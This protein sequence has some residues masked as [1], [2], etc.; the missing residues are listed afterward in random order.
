MAPLSFNSLVAYKSQLAANKYRKVHSDS[1]FGECHFGTCEGAGFDALL[2]FLKDASGYFPI[3]STRRRLFGHGH[4]RWEARALAGTRSS[5][6][7]A[8][9]M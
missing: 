3:P 9:S 6:A 8:K 4:T 5:Q 7:F 1:Q 2:D